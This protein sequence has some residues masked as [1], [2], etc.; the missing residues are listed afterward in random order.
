MDKNSRDNLISDAS[1]FYLELV[2]PV[3]VGYMA[4]GFVASRLGHSLFAS[5]AITPKLVASELTGL[6]AAFA[7][8]RYFRHQDSPNDYLPSSPPSE[9]WINNGAEHQ[10]RVAA[11]APEAAR[12][13]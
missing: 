8:H 6:A 4:R 11:A 3:G 10:G 9:V 12:T 1:S 13:A 7:C 5:T 2:T